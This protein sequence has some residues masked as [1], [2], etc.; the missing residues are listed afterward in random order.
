M[1]SRSPAFPGISCSKSKEKKGQHLIGGPG[2]NKEMANAS[3]KPLRTPS[4]TRLQLTH[5]RKSHPPAPR[6][7]PP[8][9]PDRPAGPPT[10]A[11]RPLG[12]SG[13]LGTVPGDAPV[14]ST[15]PGRPEPGGWARSAAYCTWSQKGHGF[16]G[17][18]GHFLGHPGRDHLGTPPG[19]YGSGFNGPRAVL[20][21]WPSLISL[22]SRE[23]DV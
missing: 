7:T 1:Q 21:F 2:K 8:H 17:H 23:S 14:A 10:G 3:A 22:M 15:P 19:R 13:Q 6:P 5:S 18:N 12:R 9:T 4:R 20:L 11:P 16:N